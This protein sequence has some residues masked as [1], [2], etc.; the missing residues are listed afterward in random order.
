MSLRI[1]GKYDVPPN[2]CR[3]TGPSM[4]TCTREH[5]ARRACA[6]R[7]PARAMSLRPPVP[8]DMHTSVRRLT[9]L[10]GATSGPH[11]VAS[12]A[13]PRRHVRRSMSPHP[14]VGRD[15]DD[16][17]CRMT[18]SGGATSSTAHVASPDR[19]ERHGK[20]S[21]FSRR[22]DPGS[23]RRV[24]GSPAPFRPRGKPHAP[25][26]APL[27]ASFNSA[28]VYGLPSV[29]SL[30]GSPRSSPPCSAPTFGAPA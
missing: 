6:A 8:G 21:I 9:H 7:H 18:L 28:N 5:V 15:M 3:L 14:V 19:G 22:P 12:P 29:A 11:P 10:C 4:A 20:A 1:G 25:R 16:D 30:F 17:A 24:E 27:S 13:R 2:P 23:D 26:R